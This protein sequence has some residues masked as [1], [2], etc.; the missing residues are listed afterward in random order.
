MQEK[1]A[2]LECM[3]ILA[4]FLVFVNHT[5]SSIFLDTSPSPTWFLSV[6][7]FFASKTAVPLFLLVS[8]ALLLEKSD[9]PEKSAQRLLRTGLVLFVFST[10]YYFFYAWRKGTLLGLRDFLGKLLHGNITNAFW[11]LYLYLAIL[12]ILPALQ[13]MAKAL[14][15]RVLQWILV[16]SVGVLGAVPVAQIFLPEFY[17]SPRFSQGLFSPFLGMVLWGYAIERYMPVTKARAGIAGALFLL[18]TALQTIATYL[19]FQRNPQN[20][21]V[22]DNATYLPISASAACLYIIIKYAYT[23]FPLPEKVQKSVWGLGRLTFG[24]YLLGDAAIN[25]TKPFFAFL[26]KY[27]HPLPA[28]F[29][30]ELVLFASCAAVVFLWKWCR[31]QRRTKRALGGRKKAP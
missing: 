31:A 8:G 14:D 13:C 18:L 29:L 11:Y 2:Y 16:L 27:L 23:R 24:C 9:T 19:L 30:W 28:V 21:L 4:C 7:Y 10:G 22:L 26:K 12:C 6:A 20:Y 3:R 15:R 17:L 5:N 1:K 25:L